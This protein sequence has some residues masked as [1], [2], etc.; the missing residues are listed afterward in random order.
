MLLKC[1][2]EILLRFGYRAIRWVL[3]KENV[4]ILGT[5]WK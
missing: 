2:F 3:E 5:A 4:A 1:F